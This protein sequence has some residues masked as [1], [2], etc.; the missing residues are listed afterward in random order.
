MS[1][2]KEKMNLA[3]DLDRAAHSQMAQLTSGLSPVSM[4]DAFSDWWIHLAISPGK[5]LELTTKAADH[6]MRLN[7]QALNCMQVQSKPC[8]AYCTARTRL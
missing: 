8:V 5:C 2:S 1:D 6:W 7:Q 3:R 4:M